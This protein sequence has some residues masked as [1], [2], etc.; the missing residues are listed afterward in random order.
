MSIQS[1]ASSNIFAR[2]SH[3]SL[4]SYAE[5][6]GHHSDIRDSFVASFRHANS[7]ENTYHDIQIFWSGI[8]IYFKKTI[9]HLHFNVNDRSLL[10]GT[11]H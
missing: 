8:Y 3:F 10:S 5:C 2:A 9:K 1:S 6:G 4:V 11:M 7:W